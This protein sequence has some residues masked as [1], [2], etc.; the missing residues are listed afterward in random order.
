MAAFSSL[1]ERQGAIICFPF[2]DRLT[3]QKQPCPHSCA[4]WL[5]TRPD[6]TVYYNPVNDSDNCKACGHSAE[7]HSAEPEENANIPHSRFPANAVPSM[8]PQPP[9][10]STTSLPAV[11]QP[12]SQTPS[13]FTPHI[14]RIS[15][16]WQGL[17]TLP[18][19]VG[20]KAANFRRMQAAGRHGGNKSSGAKN[21]Q[22]SRQSSV[23]PASRTLTTASLTANTGPTRF[24]FTVLPFPPNKNEPATGVCYPAYV[25]LPGEIRVWLEHLDELGQTFVSDLSPSGSV[26]NQINALAITSLERNGLIIKAPHKSPVAPDEACYQLMI[27]SN[28]AA[29][30]GFKLTAKELASSAF[31]MSALLSLPKVQNMLRESD[32]RHAL[33]IIVLAPRYGPLEAPIFRFSDDD[34]PLPEHYLFAHACYAHRELLYSSEKLNLYGSYGRRFRN[35][36]IKC[37]STCPQDPNERRTP[38]ESPTFDWDDPLPSNAFEDTSLPPGSVASSSRVTLPSSSSSSTS[39]RLFSSLMDEPPFPE[40]STHTRS[41]R[42]RSPSLQSVKDER[43]IRRVRLVSPIRDTRSQLLSSASELPDPQPLTNIETQPPTPA[44][45]SSSP[46]GNTPPSHTLLSLRLHSH[47]M[48]P[49]IMLSDER[50]SAWASGMQQR[51][52]HTPPSLGSCVSISGSSVEVLAAAVLC[53]LEHI[54]C[55]DQDVTPEAPPERLPGVSYTRPVPLR[56]FLYDQRFFSLSSSTEID[57]LTVGQGLE[58]SV[59]GRIFTTMAKDHYHWQTIGS[60]STPKLSPFRDANDTQ[61]SHALWL[62]YGAAC[63]LHL[64]HSATAPEPVSPFLLLAIILGQENFHKLTFTTVASFDPDLGRKLQPWLELSADSA[65]PEG[66]NNPVAQLLMEYEIE[67]PQVSCNR[68]SP[69]DH[70]RWTC[71]ILAKV[72]LGD[73]SIWNHAEF[74]KFQE[75]FQLQYARKNFV[76]DISSDLVPSDDGSM[77]DAKV[78]LVAALYDRHITG[79]SSLLDHIKFELSPPSS[80]RNVQVAFSAFNLSLKRYLQGRGHPDHP[81]IRTIVHPTNINQDKDSLALRSVLLMQSIYGSYLIPVIRGWRIRFNVHT[82]QSLVQTY[83]KTN[84]KGKRRADLKPNTPQKPISFHSCFSSADVELDEPLAD[85]IQTSM[86]DVMQR[87]HDWFSSPDIATD[88]DVW[89]HSQLVLNVQGFNA[90]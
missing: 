83:I 28:R 53:L 8:L 26:W 79:P 84:S 88:F 61:A 64:I 15:G 6:G 81:N 35:T 16:P 14:P 39:A 17:P 23:T 42:I 82:S 19:A 33:P 30:D 21:S 65:L 9:P 13:S 37:F 27:P 36:P 3:G 74:K 47:S 73:G 56:A 10:L 60:Y 59:W 77:I 46:S 54:H 41:G 43:P 29:A 31:T 18:E 4:I 32:P 68:Q 20:P 55:Q 66:L 57:T 48:N 70:H 12:Q 49:D 45:T 89:V 1:A 52:I 62:S 40:L 44:L 34:S 76:Q 69:S 25:P 85:L 75:G 5:G 67:V 58:R 72:L 87:G 86:D 7:Y 51:Y 22:K 2:L 71:F 50:L 90:L 11:L 24:L 78:A 63:A 80:N 38:P